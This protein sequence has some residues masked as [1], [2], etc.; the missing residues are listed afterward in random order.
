MHEPVDRAVVGQSSGQSLAAFPLLIFVGLTGVGKSTTLA[1]LAATGHP[2]TVLPDRRVLT[3]D[4]IISALQSQDGEV[5]QPVKDRGKRFEYTRRYREQYPGGMAHALTQLRVDPAL[6]GTTLLC[7][8][9]LRGAGEVRYAAQ[10]LPLA[11]FV[12]LDAPDLLRVQRLLG[13]GDTFDRL[14]TGTDGQAGEAL[15][16]PGA[17]EIFRPEELRYLQ[18]LASD[19]IVTPADL[20]SKVAIVVA[21][22]QN[23]DPAGA[24]EQ[25]ARHAA[26][27]TLV[28]DTARWQPPEIAQKI[29]DFWHERVGP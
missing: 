5:P 27:R 21:E 20:Q 7:F 9:G 2:L 19:G 12:V 1:A 29:L 25:L 16:L 4:L 8:D 22:R 6:A 13:R 23:Y 10:H 26:E 11:A 14:E 18:A 28:V 3:D 17:D 15:V 24:I